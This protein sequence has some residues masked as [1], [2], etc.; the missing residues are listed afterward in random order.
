MM[1]ILNP[2]LLVCLV[3]DEEKEEENEKLKNK[4]NLEKQ[5]NEDIKE[6]RKKEE[7]LEKDEDNYFI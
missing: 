2:N 4:E 3:V 7:N 6:K 1:L 5:R